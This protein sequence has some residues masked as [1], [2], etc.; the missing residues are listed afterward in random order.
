MKALRQMH[1][2]LDDHFN[3]QDVADNTV[4][5]TGTYDEGWSDEKVALE[6]GIA[7]KEVTR[8]REQVYGKLVDPK[9]QQLEREIE[10]ARNKILSEIRDV[11]EMLDQVTAA[12]KEALMLLDNQLKAIKVKT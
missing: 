2:L 1:R 4:L 8:W 6:S 10:K 11:Q 3:V 5:P 9:I 12:A 7:L